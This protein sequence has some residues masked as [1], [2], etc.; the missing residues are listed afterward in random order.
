MS[1]AVVR[2][3]LMHGTDNP[4][5]LVSL[6]YQVA[7]VDTAIENGNVVVLGALASGQREVRLAKAPAAD[8]AFDSIVLVATPE[9]IYDESTRKTF[10][11]FQNEAGTVA[12]GYRL[13][14]GDIFSDTIEA[15]GG[16]AKLADVKL[17]DIVELQASTKLKLVETATAN[18]TRIGTVIAKEG[19]YIVVEVI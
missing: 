1:Y 19:N 7:D 12:R 14:H 8:A 13:R 6:K 4:A 5:D 15:F 18:S 16:R 11:D 9:L 10:A 2:T 17:N 3:D